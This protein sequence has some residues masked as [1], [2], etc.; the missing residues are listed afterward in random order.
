MPKNLQRDDLLR[1]AQETM[2]RF[3]SARVFF[4]YTCERCG[5]RVTFNRPNYLFEDGECCA[6]G[7]RQKVTEGGYTLDFALDGRA[8]ANG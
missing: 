1:H 6:C 2:K 7:H 5:E 4:K 3:P 8:N